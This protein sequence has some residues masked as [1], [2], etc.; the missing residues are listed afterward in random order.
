M[1]NSWEKWAIVLF[2]LKSTAA[3]AAISN[4]SVQSAT[5]QLP[6]PS[7]KCVAPLPTAA[8][9]EKVFKKIKE[10][11]RLKKKKKSPWNG[12]NAQLGYVVNTGNS[13]NSNL[14]AGLNVLYNKP[15]WANTF[16]ANAYLNKSLGVVTKEQYFL[17][18]QFTYYFTKSRR[19]YIFSNFRF[20]E[21]RF[22]PYEYQVV[23]SAGYGRELIKTKRFTLSAQAGPGIRHD[24]IRTTRIYDN[25]LILSTAMTMNWQITSKVALSEQLNYDIGPPFDYLNSVTA[26]TATLA[27]HLAA[28]L[29]Y[30]V[31]YYSKIPM[32]SSNTEKTDTITN[33]ALVYN[34]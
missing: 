15:K 6:K 2:S 28:Q 10:E 33:I 19:N 4:T 8:S 23:F 24:F 3:F 32:G 26:L 9:C 29:S 7:Q 21:D 18:N 11:K 25:H 14:S 5:K 27:G 30:T 12:T 34:F 20:I 1:L 13:N 16:Q 31:Q 22:S 17:T